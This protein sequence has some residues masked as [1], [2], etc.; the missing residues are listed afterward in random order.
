MR[1]LKNVP[2]S[3]NPEQCIS[4]WNVPN[5]QRLPIYHSE[6]CTC[7]LLTL[8]CSQS[9]LY[10]SF[11]NC[12]C[13]YLGKEIEVQ[14]RCISYHVLLWIAISRLSTL[15]FFFF[16]SL[17][18]SFL[19]CFLHSIYLN[20]YHHLTR[21]HVSICTL[22]V[23]RILWCFQS[24]FQPLWVRN[25]L[26]SSDYKLWLLSL[27]FRFLGFFRFCLFLIYIFISR[28][29]LK[30]CCPSCEFVFL[31]CHTILYLVSFMK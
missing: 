15:F 27:S 14:S 11:G 18:L 22:R 2:V 21:Y 10:F 12:S 17:F 1:F 25:Y 4:P 13:V 16:L 20:T 24:L 29:Y 28:T 6:F 23:K 30:I 8:T 5:K 3:T 9:A 7:I 31:A 26:Q 19:P